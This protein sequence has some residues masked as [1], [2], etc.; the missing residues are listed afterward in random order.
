[1]DESRLD[2]REWIGWMGVDWMD[3]SRLDGWE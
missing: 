2:G 3:G 1:M